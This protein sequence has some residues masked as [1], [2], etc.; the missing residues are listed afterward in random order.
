MSPPPQP[1]HQG[2]VKPSV[3][4]YHLCKLT[5]AYLQPCI[6][7]LCLDP[8]TETPPHSTPPLFSLTCYALF[9]PG[10]LFTSHMSSAL[11]YGSKCT[12][13]TPGPTLWKLPLS[14]SPKTVFPFW[15][16][17]KV[18]ELSYH[19]FR[20]CCITFVNVTLST[21]DQ[22][23]LLISYVHSAEALG[24]QEQ[25]WVCVLCCNSGLLKFY[26]VNQG[27]PMSR[28]EPL[29]HWA[30]EDNV[31]AL[32]CIAVSRVLCPWTVLNMAWSLLSCPGLMYFT[33]SNFFFNF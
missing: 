33:S 7:L 27:M 3:L 17:L 2:F 29:S 13:Q 16:F 8:L 9:I 14:K 26:V 24:W 12:A 18:L 31:P 21:Q 22:Q 11:Q 23:I 20:F 4:R 5:F 19:G 15:F 28:E 10:E 30:F 6:L 1:T 32:C 25:P